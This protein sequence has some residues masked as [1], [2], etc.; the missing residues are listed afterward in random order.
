MDAQLRGL[1]SHNAPAKPRWIL[2][3]AVLVFTSSV[4]WAIGHHSAAS[5]TPTT[6]SP[7]DLV[8]PNLS[9]D[10]LNAWCRARIAAGTAGLTTRA[11]NWLTDCVAVSNP[12]PTPSPSPSPS[13]SPTPTTPSPTPTTPSPTPTTP[14]PTPTTPSPTPTGSTWPGASNTGVPAGTVLTAYTG[15][16]TI[17]VA[18][19]V[20]D[21]KAIT[22]AQLLIKATGVKVTRSSITGSSDPAVA[23]SGGDL[24][25]SDST[26]VAAVNTTGLGDNNWT[27]TRVNISGGNRGANCDNHCTLQDSW[28]HGQRV[29]GTTHASVLRAGE[30]TTAIHNTLNCEAPADNCSADLTGYPDFAPTHDWTIT[31]NLFIAQHL[32]GGYFCSYGGASAG[33]P[34]SNDPANAVNIQF[35]NNTYQHGPGG[36]CGGYPD[37]APISDYNASKPGWVF[38]GN[39]WDTGEPVTL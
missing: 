23:V 11:R 2:Y 33:K 24:A 22:C 13:P 39:V 4:A 16:C 26:I 27:A 34:F 3:L 28:L 38:S 5:T 36:W 37:G 20:I 9:G 31:G 18:N 32:G 14:S 6:A 35:R 1:P 12:L 21:A 7:V 10:D 17:T 25:I 8:V 29:S 15:P 19:T 30:F